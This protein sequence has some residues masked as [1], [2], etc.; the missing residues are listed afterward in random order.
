MCS[1]WCHREHNCQSLGLGS[2]SGSAAVTLEKPKKVMKQEINAQKIKSGKGNVQ[3]TVD[4][5]DVEWAEKYPHQR[6]SGRAP[7]CWSRVHSPCLSE[8]T[9]TAVGPFY[10]VSKPGEVKIPHW[11]MEKTCCGLTE[12]MVSIYINPHRSCINCCQE[13]V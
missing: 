12:S 8:E 5:T 2:L 10:L 7:Y 11:E 13:T 1:L 6:K 4:A 3:L 9:L